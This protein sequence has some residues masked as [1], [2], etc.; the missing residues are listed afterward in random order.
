MKTTLANAEAALDDVQRDTRKLH[1]R[2]LRAA[3]EKYIEEQREQ[4]KALRRMMN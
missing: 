2:E 1:S 3:I 4:I